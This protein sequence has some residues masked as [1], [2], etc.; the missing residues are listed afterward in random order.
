MKVPRARTTKPKGRLRF[1]LCKV[2][3]MTSTKMRTVTKAGGKRDKEREKSIANWKGA[4]MTN[5]PSTGG[6]RIGGDSRGV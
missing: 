5:G 4:N 6:K 3:R 1:T 2:K